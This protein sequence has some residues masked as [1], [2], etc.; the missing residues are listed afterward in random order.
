MSADS[1]AYFGLAGM[2]NIISAG[3]K[4]QAAHVTKGAQEGARLAIDWL[5]ELTHG[6]GYR[7][8]HSRFTQEFC[9]F[10]GRSRVDIETG[11]PLESCCLG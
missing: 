11:A 8:F 10:F 7:L 4:K 6:R 5:Q 9:R 1:L 2:Q 3:E